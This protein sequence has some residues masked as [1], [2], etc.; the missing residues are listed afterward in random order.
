MLG[1]PRCVTMKSLEVQD[2]VGIDPNEPE[3]LD[4]TAVIVFAVASIGLGGLSLISLLGLIGF[5]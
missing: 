3:G 5:G 4:I 1:T 2:S